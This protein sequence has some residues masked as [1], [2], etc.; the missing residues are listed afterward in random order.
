MTIKWVDSTP[1]NRRGIV[2]KRP[3]DPNFRIDQKDSPI[4]LDIVNNHEYWDE[5]VKIWSFTIPKKF[6]AELFEDLKK[7][8]ENIKWKTC[9]WVTINEKWLIISKMY[10]SAQEWAEPIWETNNNHDQKSFT[11]S[12]QELKNV[13][14][15]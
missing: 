1:G 15:K 8:N 11:I 2:D 13:Y 3:N 6:G 14:W 5:T 12:L 7:E 9:Q 10:S 4:S